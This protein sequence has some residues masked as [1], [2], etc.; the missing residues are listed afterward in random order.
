MKVVKCEKH[1][2][3]NFW[4]RVVEDGITIGGNFFPTLKDSDYFPL[5]EQGDKVEVSENGID[6]Y[7]NDCV[8]VANYKNEFIINEPI[9][10]FASANYIRPIEKEE[11]DSVLTL[12]YGKNVNDVDV[13]LLNGI[14]YLPMEK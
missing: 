4:G 6:W 13:I 14:K 10:Q 11:Y 7:D 2:P 1:I 5:P 3:E 9:I 8:Y 12:D